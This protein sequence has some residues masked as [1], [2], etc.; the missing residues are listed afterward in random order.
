MRERAMKLLSIVVAC[1]IGCFSPVTASLAEVHG[2]PYD[3]AAI[4]A[5]LAENVVAL[6]NHDPIGASRQ[7]MPE[8]EFTNVAGIRLKGAA[9]IEKFLATGFATRLKAATW[10]TMETS[11]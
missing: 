11:V 8:T 10:K 4:K 5:I 7:Y 3:M 1:T 9:A 6:T 2:A